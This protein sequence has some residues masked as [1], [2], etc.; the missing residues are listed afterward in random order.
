MPTIYDIIKLLFRINVFRFMTSFS[1]HPLIAVA[2][3]IDWTDRH[4][5][6]FF[7]LFSPNVML[8][9]EMITAPA[10]IH[11]DRDYLL[12]YDP[13]EHPLALQ[14]GGSDPVM[15]A[16]CAKIAEDYGYDQINF[17]VGCPSDRV[18]SGKFGACL[19][20]EPNLV[21]DCIAAMRKSVKIPV[22]LKT[23]L[24]VDDYD[25]YEFL[26]DFVCKVAATGCD[27]FI[28]HAR[29]AWLNGLSPKENREIPPLR[30]EAVYQLKQDFPTLKIILNG[31]I[32]TVSEVKQQLDSVDG[33]MIGREIYYRPF[34]LAEI[35]R[36]FF[37]NYD[38]ILTPDSILESLLPYIEKQLAKGTRLSHLTRHIM[39]LYQGVP[40]V[41]T[42]RRYLSEH[43]HR[44]DAGIEVV[45]A[46]VQEIK[47]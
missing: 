14:I 33:V 41:R 47:L 30:Y 32:K 20:K 8:Y 18:Q 22:T 19:M 13:S 9:T 2:P 27:T 42:W 37:S 43:A 4:C 34:F 16:A 10:I 38:N 36:E 39:G 44:F 40:G 6:Y 21:A 17:N 3:M 31:G 35:E 5:R 29:K 28:I 45:R 46:A 23:R 12:G 1:D 25:S 24:G 11:G 15:L 26:H 7:R